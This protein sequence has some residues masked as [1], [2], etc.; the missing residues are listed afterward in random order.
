MRKNRLAG[1]WGLGLAIIVG[2]TFPCQAKVTLENLKTEP[3]DNY[4]ADI[5]PSSQWA[6]NNPIPNNGS[7]SELGNSGAGTFLRNNQS[8]RVRTGST[9]TLDFLVI[10][11]FQTTWGSCT[12]KLNVNSPAGLFQSE[13][14]YAFELDGRPNSG[15]P[16]L[17]KNITGLIPNHNYSLRVSYSAQ[18]N[19]GKGCGHNFKSL[20][21]KWNGS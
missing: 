3:L 10:G 18:Q 20:S 11:N 14:A 19:S 16:S 21:Y 15:T 12:Y 1:A 8:F 2:F 17:A 5:A 9:G 4:G 7:S 13:N 6:T